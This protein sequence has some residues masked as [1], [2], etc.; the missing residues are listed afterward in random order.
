MWTFRVLRDVQVL[1][2]SFRRQF[3]SS[4]LFATQ[5]PWPESASEVYQPSDRSLLAK[6][7]PTIADRGVASSAQRIPR[8][9]S[10]FSR[11]EPPLFLPSSSSIVLTRLCGPRSRPTGNR[12]LDLWICSQEHWP[13][14]YRG[15]LFAIR[16]NCNLQW[17]TRH[18]KTAQCGS[19]ILCNLITETEQLAE[20]AVRQP[21]ITTNLI[22]CGSTH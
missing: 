5:T 7:V 14:D 12:T 2:W 21:R 13:L 4:H 9:Y 6:L 15:G 17:E 8:P 11:P 20:K 10:R 16:G 22:K 3:I 19:A 1:N 18:D